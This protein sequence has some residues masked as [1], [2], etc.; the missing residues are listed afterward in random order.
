MKEGGEKEG[1]K[2]K[3][4]GRGEKEGMCRVEKEVGEEREKGEG[5]KVGKRRRKKE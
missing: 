2:I 5:S 4:K 3:M 1:E